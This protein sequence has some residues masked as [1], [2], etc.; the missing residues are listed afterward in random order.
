MKSRREDIQ[1]FAIV[2]E[3]FINAPLLTAIPFAKYAEAAV[4]PAATYSP[5]VLDRP[6]TI[7]YLTSHHHTRLWTIELDRNLH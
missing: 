6:S 1:I 2:P 7:E 5:S 3:F 4:P